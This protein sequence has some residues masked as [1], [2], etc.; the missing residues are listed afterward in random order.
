MLPTRIPATTQGVTREQIART[1]NAT[2]SEDAL[3]CY[4][5]ELKFDL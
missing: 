1:V 4:S 2:D 3:K 5:A